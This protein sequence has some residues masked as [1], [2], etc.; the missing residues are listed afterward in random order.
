M[1]LRFVYLLLMAMALPMMAAAQPVLIGRVTNPVT[2]AEANAGTRDPSL[3]GDG[4]Y[5]VFASSSTT[6]G[7]TANGATNIYRYDLSPNT[8]AADTL[9]LAMA[10]LGNGN[11]LAPSASHSGNQIAF[12]SLATN[13]GG[14]HGPFTDVY[15]SEA[16][17]LP[18]NEV[19]FNTF[20]VSRGLG[21]VAPN[22]EARYPSISADGRFIAFYSDA[23]NLIGGD[24]NAA[25]DIFL[26]QTDALSATPELISVDSNEVPIAGPSRALTANAISSDG[27]Y[28]AFAARGA[29]DGANPGNL[30]DVYVRDRSAGTTQLISKFSD[31]AAFTNSSDQASISSNGRYVV[32]RSFVLNGPGLTGS[33]V[34]LRD[35]QTSTT[36]NLPKPPLVNNCEDPHVANNADIVLQCSS[37]VVGVPQQAYLYRTSTGA[38]YRLST[39][40]GG[41]DGNGTSG[42]FMDM[43]ADGN[44]IMFDSAASNLVS[45]DGNNSGDVFLTVDFEF[46]NRIFSDGFE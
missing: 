40:I 38:Y 10:M 37:S 44:F 2:D 24:N 7:P 46:L 43:S 39:A 23:S 9:I 21:G 1:N 15:L 27:R 5:I 18:Q 28:V 41:G 14:N 3:S 45:G 42:G 26:A 19:G 33:M 11:S 4:R 22:G 32:F 16:F 25:P 34:F 20:L 29:L 17:A 36:L 30:E 13:L 31:G 6:L 35:R 12:E 8:P